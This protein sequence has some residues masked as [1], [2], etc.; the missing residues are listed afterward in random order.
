MP[1]NY[2]T[3]P[4]FL[5]MSTPLGDDKLQL[6][7]FTGYEAM[8]ELFR[9]QIDFRAKNDVDVKFDQLIGKPI[10]FGVNAGD[11]PARHFSGICIE[12]SQGGRGTELTEYT[13]VVV[14]KAWALTQSS[15]SR[16]FQQKS[17]PDILRA[18]IT[19]FD[20]EYQF[21]Q[22]YEKRE[23]CVQY[24][25][26]DWDF[27]CRLLEDEGMYFYFKFTVGS[28]KL[29][30][31][32][33]ARL[34]TEVADQATVKFD[35]VGG[36]GDTTMR[37]SDLR[38]SQTWRTG[39]VTV[40]DHNFQLPHKSNDADKE[41]I[42]TVQGGTVTHKLKVNGN[43]K[44]EIYEH[45]GD[46]AKWFDGIDKGGGEQASE[47]GKISSQ[48]TRVAGVRMEQEESQ[49]LL[50]LGASDCRNFVP[51]H[52][53][54]LEEHYNAND[55]YILTSVSHTAAEGSY[56]SGRDEISHYENSFTCIPQALKFR[57]PRRTPKPKLNCQ[58]AVVV[59]PAGEEIFTDKYGR[60]KVQFHWDRDGTNDTSSSCWLRVAT[61]W[62]GAKWGTIHI[63]RIKMEVLVDFLEGDPDRPIIIGSLYNS[64][65]MP[66]YALPDNKTQSGIKSRSSKG[67]GADNYNELRFEDKK[68]DEMITLH[69]EKDMEREVEHDDRIDIGNDQKI[70]VHHD[71][72]ETV[73]NDEKIE[74]KN[75][76][77]NKIAQKH[78]EEIGGDHV[79]NVKMNKKVKVGMNYNIESGMNVTIKS[80]VGINI[81][82]GMSITLKAGGSSIQ[83]NPGGIQISGV[84]MLML[85]CPG[86]PPP[87]VMPVIIP[88]LMPGQPAPPATP[89]APGTAAA[90]S[91]SGPA[92]KPGLDLSAIQVPTL[93]P[94]PA[95]PDSGALASQ[96]TTMAK[97][98]L[99]TATNVL[100]NM[101]NTFMDQV[102]NTA[103]TLMNTAQNLGQVAASTAG[104]IAEQ[105][106]KAVDKAKEDI[107]K[108]VDG[109]KSKVE[110]ALDSVTD[111]AKNAVKQVAQ[112]V[113]DLQTQAAGALDQAQQQLQDVAAQAEQMA[114]QAKEQ[115]QQALQQ[116]SEA[117]N[118][119]AKQAQQVAQQAQAQ[120]QDA[121]QQAQK[122]ADQAMEQGQQALNAASQ[123]LDALAEQGKQVAVAV[124][125]AALAAVQQAQQ[126]AQ[127]AMA[128]AEQVANQ[129][130]Q[131]A[132][133]AAQ[134]AQQAAQRA[135][136]ATQEAAQEAAANAQKVAEDTKQQVEGAVDG[137][138][139]QVQDAAQHAQEEVKQA[140]Q[141]ATQAAQQAGEMAQKQAEQI[142][143]QVG[144]A[145]E[146]AAEQIGKTADQAFTQVGNT[147]DQ[148]AKGVQ[149]AF[150]GLGG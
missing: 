128:Q 87:P 44:F 116:A 144:Q 31:T 75:N 123:Q 79:Q 146:Q 97:S 39:K 7:Q 137:A 10:S 120:L 55:A 65:E 104:K 102:K 78:A 5:Y 141:Q 83:I 67:G 134:Q 81:E 63:P 18:V 66:P 130:A 105:V 56:R 71:R 136:A 48:K 122:I 17:I 16:I 143:G 43:D 29:V 100:S 14:P 101:S 50:F 76:R 47:L 23:Y 36:Q 30:V 127:E 91:A 61:P 117:A 124:Q 54:T 108:A 103:D 150:K 60:V 142:A 77:T 46:Y 68:G 82:S 149:N 129:M 11:M 6:H 40:W 88:P 53:F 139:K 109:A 32:D 84:P 25:E 135:M 121:A 140:A 145:A 58:T 62:A 49:M 80:G 112:Q 22:T 21:D 8:S 89:A 96:V 148:A 4:R 12:L 126:M 115:G 13:M 72:T 70:D 41:V 45:P 64:R 111:Q 28:H 42:T 118:Q 57:A 27:V 99:D 19:G 38:R 106:G 110:G 20:V 35:P 73:D 74:I 125:Q 138:T 1:D 131:Q 86:P 133:Q 90:S 59:G 147:A 24:R 69:A 95:L 85:N 51:G 132:Q 119:V 34:T 114:N 92:A 107:G 2:G 94:P 26:T 113:A 15:R 98:S 9:Y 37:I 3:V 93:P 52:K 33:K